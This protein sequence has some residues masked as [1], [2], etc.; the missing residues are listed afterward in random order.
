MLVP[1]VYGWCVV[2]LLATAPVAMWTIWGEDYL[3]VTDRVPANVIVVEAWM[4][5]EGAVAAMAEYKQASDGSDYIVAAGALSGESWYKERWDEVEIVESALRHRGFPSQRFIRARARDTE[6]H[7]T[8]QAAVAVRNAL[9]VAGVHP[10]GIN[11]ITIGPHARRSRMIFAK[12]L[13]PDIPV[14]VIAWRPQGLPHERW[15]KSSGRA[16]DFL[17]ETV[18]IVFE[19]FFSSGR[20]L[21]IAEASDHPAK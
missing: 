21:G 7:R 3:A 5:E 6:R 15:W 9:A 2:L 11:V 8:Y 4:H 17:K 20:W 16:V 13:G 19:G 18:G 1:T 12:V 14:G 10:T